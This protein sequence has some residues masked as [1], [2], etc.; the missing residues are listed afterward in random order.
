MNELDFKVSIKNIIKFSLPSIIAMIISSIYSIV[1]GIVASNYI[2]NEAFASV[3]I[4]YPIVGMLIAIGTMIGA[5]TI[6]IVSTKMGMNK[7][8]EARENLSQSI[9]FTIILSIVLSALLY[10]F[11]NEIVLL[12]GANRDIS[13]LCVEYMKPIILFLPMIILQIEFSYYFVANGKPNLSLISSI[14]GGMTNVILDIL[15]TKFLHLGVSSIAMASGIGYTIG[16]MMGLIY[17]LIKKTNILYLVKPKFDKKVLIKS[18]TN[19]SSEMVTNISSSITTVLFNSIMM[20][21]LGVN[22]VSA[23]GIMVYIDFVLVALGLGYA[24]GISPIIGYNYGKKDKNSLH[25]VIKNSFIL[26][27]IFSIL[28]AILVF[29]FKES[30]I[31]IFARKGT[32]VYKIALYGISIYFLSYLF[33]II[34]VFISAMFTAL[35]NGK[36]SAFL[37]CIRTL[38]LI[39]IFVLLFVKLFGINGL[40]YAL[41]TAELLALFIGIFFVKRYKKVYNY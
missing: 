26:C 4:I 8:K 40:W 18:L 15:F 16:A 19:G 1:D 2:S 6:A 21:H 29:I 39:V 20:K 38:I 22:G 30:L 9:I 23:I 24:Q 3:N 28:L 14:I 27:T 37:S 5:G 11:R 34:N 31:E 33:K 17:F 41:P 36:V 13:K 32:E 7:N 12:L 25:L 10:I 35:S